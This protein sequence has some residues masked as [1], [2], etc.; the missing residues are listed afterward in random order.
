MNVGLGGFKL[1]LDVLSSA[2]AVFNL[3]GVGKEYFTGSSKDMLPIEQS[4]QKFNQ[5]G[6]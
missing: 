2:K 4:H 5:Y 1:A 3:I 6:N